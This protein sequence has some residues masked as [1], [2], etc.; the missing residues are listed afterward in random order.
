[1]RLDVLIPSLNRGPL[2]E[3][4]LR[5]VLRAVRPAELDLRIT[6]ILNGSTDDSAAR[7]HALSQDAPGTIG[8]VHERRRGKSRALN[9]GI[10]ATSGEVVA[11]I[12]DDEEVDRGWLTEIVRVFADRTIDFAGGPYVAV[13]A[14]PAPPWVPPDYLAVVGSAEN[15]E[16]EREYGRDFPGILKGGNAVIRRRTL[17][18][19]GPYAEY[20]GPARG[21]RLFSCE[22][23]EMYWRLIEMGARGRYVPSMIIYHHVLPGRL[24][25]GYYRRWCFWRGVSRGLMDHRHPLRVPYLAG[26]P[27]FLFG[28][29]A[30][31]MAG[32]ARRALGEAPHPSRALA[33]EL[34]VLD[35]TGYWFGRHIYTLARFS[36]VRNRRHPS[37]TFVVP[38]QPPA[39]Q[40]LTKASA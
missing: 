22:D 5:S 10:A 6:V 35:L 12:D 15:G 19:A 18:A 31:G 9:A 33:D 13:W 30:H 36:P 11:M 32:I 1:M 25:P 23:E 8:I 27:R 29:A 37:G 20:L 21:A 16:I 14:T 24:T 17:L 7:I 40:P 26:V 2:L 4:A 28:R 39:P 3:R 34:S 38:P